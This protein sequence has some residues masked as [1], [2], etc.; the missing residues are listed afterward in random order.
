MMFQGVG[1]RI[2]RDSFSGYTPELYYTDDD[3]L[4][5][6]GDYDSRRLNEMLSL[7]DTYSSGISSVSLHQ[8][9]TDGFIKFRGGVK[10]VS[11]LW[12]FRFTLDASRVRESVSFSG[13]DVP[14]SK[15]GGY[16]FVLPKCGEFF[17]ELG[18]IVDGERVPLL[19]DDY[20]M[21]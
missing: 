6:I 14:S 16:I 9:C 4:G 3:M 8:E 20:C 18:E 17:C 2:D 21:K 10:N 7:I 19:I 13:H 12:S 11:S 1:F 15:S 5:N